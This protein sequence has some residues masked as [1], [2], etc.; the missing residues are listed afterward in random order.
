[1]AGRDYG[2]WG[3]CEARA[4][5]GAWCEWRGGVTGGWEMEKGR[6]GEE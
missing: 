5:G 1:M 2:A 6:M 3:A 4:K